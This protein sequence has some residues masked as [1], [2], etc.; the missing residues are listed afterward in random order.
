MDSSTAQVRHGA[1]GVIEAVRE[2]RRANHQRELDDLSFIE[3]FPQLRQRAVA[4]RRGAPR[5]PFG[6]QNYGF[7]FVLEQRAALVELQRPNLL[8]GDPNP[9][10]RS[11]VRSRSIFAAAVHRGFQEGKLLRPPFALPPLHYPTIAPPHL[12]TDTPPLSH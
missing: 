4:N 11:G 10:R 6:V 7:L 8:V 5:D 1:Q 9:L 2:I 3:K 12:P